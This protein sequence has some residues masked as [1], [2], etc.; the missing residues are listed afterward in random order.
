MAGRYALVCLLP[1]GDGTPDDPSHFDR[2]M[3]AEFTV[4]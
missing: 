3:W 1:I 2:G 4:K